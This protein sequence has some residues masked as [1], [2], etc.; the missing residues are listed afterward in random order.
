MTFCSLRFFA[1]R[2]C[3]LPPLAGLSLHPRARAGAGGDQEVVSSL[4]DFR[5]QREDR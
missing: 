2:P 3:L 4:I 1:F 5:G